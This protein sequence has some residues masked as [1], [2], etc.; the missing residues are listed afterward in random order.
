MNHEK[1]LHKIPHTIYQELL[2]A[3]EGAR[4]RLAVAIAAETKATP[5]AQWKYYLDTAD[6]MRR[7]LKQLRSVSRFS[8]QDEDCWTQALDRLNQIAERS[9]AR[10]RGGEAHQ[11]CQH[12]RAVLV[13]LDQID[14]G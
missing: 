1:N 13:L 6:R 14:R 5:A 4:T 8:T 3:L 10:V 2:K 7:C 12:L 11:L 9:D